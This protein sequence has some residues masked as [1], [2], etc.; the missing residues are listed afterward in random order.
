MP[1]SFEPRVHASAV[2]MAARRDTV[3]TTTTRLLCMELI[4][5]YAIAAD[6]GRE[7]SSFAGALVGFLVKVST[8]VALPRE[9]K[10]SVPP[11]A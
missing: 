7:F 6:A 10:L 2:G 9:L 8:I 4:L 11:G 3:G 5:E 1:G